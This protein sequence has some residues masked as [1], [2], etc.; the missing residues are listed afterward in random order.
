MTDAI[1]ASGAHSRRHGI[2][3]GRS[4]CVVPVLSLG[5]RRRLRRAVGNG[6]QGHETCLFAGKALHE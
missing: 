1:G 5:S 4:E 3:T 2:E 6:L